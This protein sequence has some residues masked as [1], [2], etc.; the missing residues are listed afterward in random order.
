MKV[1]TL[2]SSDVCVVPAFV[3]PQKQCTVRRGTYDD[4]RTSM[5]FGYTL[6]VTNTASTQLCAHFGPVPS[7]KL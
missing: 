7:S 3:S 2:L 5:C 1:S 4:R 6:L